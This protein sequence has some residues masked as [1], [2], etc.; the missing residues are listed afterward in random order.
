MDNKVFFS[1]SIS[2]TYSVEFRGCLASTNSH[3]YVVGGEASSGFARRNL[4]IYDL[5]QYAWDH[6]PAMNTGRRSHGCIVEPISLQ[7][8][9]IAGYDGSNFLSSI[10]SININSLVEWN[11]FAQ[12]LSESASNLRAVVFDG[13]IYCV[14]GYSNDGST[15]YDREK[16]HIIDPNSN[17]VSILGHTLP[18]PGLYSI[19]TTIV[20]NV[21]YGFGG[22]YLDSNGND[23]SVNSWLQFEMLSACHT[24]QHEKWL[25]LLS[26]QL[27]LQPQHRLVCRHLL[28]LL[29]QLQHQR[30]FQH[31]LRLPSHRKVMRECR[32]QNQ[33]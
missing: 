3:L 30:T 4:Q 8:F 14:G 13:L 7:L 20:E 25:F 24:C 16:V 18:S 17:T 33:I 31:R 32:S 11:D 21:I 6:G 28:P 15:K 2:I 5:E 1:S 23:Y 12:S 26:D 19:G 29:T 10:E 22:D 9:A 27:L